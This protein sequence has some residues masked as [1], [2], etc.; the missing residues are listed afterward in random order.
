M[1]HSSLISPSKVGVVLVCRCLVL[2]IIA[3]IRIIFCQGPRQVVNA[4]T[5]YSVFQ[6]NLEPTEAKNVGSALSQFF[7]NIGLLAKKNNQQAVILSGMLF[8]LIIWIFA[9]LSL[10]L[11]VLFYVLFLWHHIPNRD[12]GLVPFCERSINERLSSIVSVKV[13]KAI[14]EEER[15]RIKADVKAAKKGEMPQFGRQATLP[16]V[17][18]DKS[19]G[20]KLP[21]MPMLNR[22]DTMTTLPLYASRP[23]TPSSN[24][25]TLPAFEM[26]QLSQIRPGPSRTVTGS[27]ALSNASYASNAPLMGNASDMGYGRSPS[28]APSL[29]PLD[30]NNY[31]QRSTAG[32]T[33]TT[34]FSRG[35]PRM[36]SA[37]GDRGYTQSP[38]SYSDNQRPPPALRNDSVDQYGRPNPRD[39]RSNTPSGPPPSM[40]RRTPY[41]QSDRPSPA[42]SSDYGRS[43]PAPPQAG[44]YQPYNP[45][46]SQRSAS[47]A[48]YPNP[49][50]SPPQHPIITDPNDYFGAPLPSPQRAAT[51]MSGSYTPNG[52]AGSGG[53]GYTGSEQGQGQRQGPA[54]LASPAPYVNNM[55][56]R[57]SPGFV[58]GGFGGGNGGVQGQGGY[59]R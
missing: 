44:G 13:N 39:F 17:F 42:P 56:G 10:I 1:S 36:Q 4:L 30:T 21:N 19:D 59:R 2:T 51:G 46:T 9:A 38:I 41:E 11:A 27:S 54:R 37:M 53:L 26:D 31:P 20:D 3:W 22:N 43:S 57:G 50:V 45:N 23:G 15:K 16:V 47:A 34:N 8:T 55:N 40:G 25:P 33:N 35:P 24:Q 14:E 58:N 32:S 12:G 49:N 7:Q 6:A 52:R 29:P 5:L 18:A 28:P 48:P